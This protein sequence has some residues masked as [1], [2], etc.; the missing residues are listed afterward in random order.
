[1]STL[2][3]LNGSKIILD[4]LGVLGESVKGTCLVISQHLKL[5]SRVLSTMKNMSYHGNMKEKR[6]KVLH[7]H[8]IPLLVISSSE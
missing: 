4:L 7:L 1:V 3:R 2:K 5:T 6:K 8:N